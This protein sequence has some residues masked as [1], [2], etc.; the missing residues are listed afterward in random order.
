M[1]AIKHTIY[2]SSQMA[3]WRGAWPPTTAFMGGVLGCLGDTDLDFDIYYK[4]FNF[5]FFHDVTVI[6]SF[7][8]HV[9]HNHND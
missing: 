4:V 1:H 3:V 6:Y 5:F 7:F 8:Q 2:K 9:A